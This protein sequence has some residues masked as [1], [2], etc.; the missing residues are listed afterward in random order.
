M[1]EV[2]MNAGEAGGVKRHAAKRRRAVAKP[3]HTRSLFNARGV[4]VRRQSRRRTKKRRE[5]AAHAIVVARTR[6]CCGKNAVKRRRAAAKPP[7][8]RSLL[9]ARGVAVR[10]P[11][12]E[13]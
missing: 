2:L 8:T 12:A 1:H 5:A 4:A 10:S 13:G 3:P 9:H 11:P 6:C 7:H